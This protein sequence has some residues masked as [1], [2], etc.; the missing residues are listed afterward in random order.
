[1]GTPTCS[2]FP[3]VANTFSFEQENDNYV[4]NM[5]NTHTRQGG[6]F[7]VVN[8]FATFGSHFLAQILGSCES[9]A[10]RCVWR[11]GKTDILTFQ[12][13][14]NK[15]SR[16]KTLL[17]ALPVRLGTRRRNFGFQLSS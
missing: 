7:V 9:G 10:P 5:R 4:L 15:M 1:M 14:E 6:S 13:I 12:F 2:V 11:L 8:L 17:F 3:R 16:F